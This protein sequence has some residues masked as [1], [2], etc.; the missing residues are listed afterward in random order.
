MGIMHPENINSLESLTAG[1][2]R[3]FWFLQEAAKPDK[4]YLCFFE[5]NIGL[6]GK[7][8]DFLLFNNK[9]GLL[10]IEVK[11]WTLPQI[12]SA[13]HHQF[14]VKIAGE[15]EL[16]TNPDRQAKGYVNA[17]INRLKEIPGFQSAQLGRVGNLKVPI[18]RMIAFP[19]ISREEYVQSEV[20]PN[21]IFPEKIFFREDIDLDGKICSDQSGRTFLE[22]ISPAFLFKLEPLTRKEIDRLKNAIYPELIQ[23][24][25]RTGPGK[26]HFQREVQALDENQ[27]QLAR[28]LGSG[29]QIIKG[30]PGCGKTLVLIHRCCQLRKYNP[31]IKRILLVCYNI[32]LASYL[33]RLLQEKGV[34]LGKEGVEVYHFYELCADILGQNVEYDNHDS[35]FYQLVLSETLDAI[36]NGS[37]LV[38]LCDAILV[39]EGQ[40]F[41]DDMLKI[42]LGLLSPQ[43]NLVIAVDANQ[44]LYRKNSSWKSLG[45]EA[46]GRSHYLEYTYR[47]TAEIFEFSQRFL[48]TS[49]KKKPRTGYLPLDFSLHGDP[50][51]L[52]PF[53]N[54]ETIGNFMV[55][56]IKKQIAGG[57]YK[58]SEIAIIYDDKAYRSD[59][60][61][62]GSRDLPRK[63]QKT[64]EQSGIP[65]KWVSEDVRAKEMFDITTDRV[66]LISIHSAKGL[67]FDLVYLVN[68]E[69]IIP[70]DKTRAHFLGVVYVALTRAKHRLVILFSRKTEFIEKML[71]TN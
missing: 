33:K 50:P 35:E 32:A 48:G 29:H 62:Y 59:T 53:N 41:N 42:I 12:R 26:N 11:D 69:N 61:S 2:E 52:I 40:D 51:Q 55:T 21:L 15:N 9:C 16:R 19:N 18:G 1:E 20:L 44:D 8:P 25:I 70:D 13:D 14:T 63:L 43:G 37:P 17:L 54:P 5:P 22:R 23:L 31:G 45:I 28:N 65:V 49:I 64:L 4:D 38:D 68:I 27:A 67:D 36:K 30:P 39:D 6:E 10:V 34:G 60:F 71:K 46:K 47:N 3:V 56:D 57:E 58:R 66:S 24:P 7:V